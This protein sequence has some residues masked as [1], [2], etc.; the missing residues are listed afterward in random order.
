MK[1]NNLITPAFYVKKYKNFF[2]KLRRLDFLAKRTS[3]K[4]RL[5]KSLLLALCLLLITESSPFLFLPRVYAADSLTVTNPSTSNTAVNATYNFTYS[6]SPTFWRIYIDADLNAGT[7]FAA[8][9]GVGADYLV[10]N[11]TVYKHAGGDWSWTEI[12]SAI[13]STSNPVV[14]WTIARNLIAETQA[15]GEKSALLF[16]VEDSTGNMGTSSIYNHVFTDSCNT[17]PTPTGAITPTP[18]GAITPTPTKAPTVTPSPTIGATPTP[19]APNT[20]PKITLTN[21]P[22][23][24]A[25]TG[26]SYTLTWSDSDPD[27]NALV[28]LYLD[29]DNTGADGMLIANNLKEDDNGGSGQ[30]AFDVSAVTSGSYYIYAVVE[31]KSNTPVISYSP[32]KLTIT[33]NTPTGGLAGATEGNFDVNSLGAATY[34]VPISVSPGTGGIQPK[35]SLSY[36]SQAGNGILGMGFAITGLSSISRCAAT[37]A[38]DGYSGEVTFGAGDKFCLDGE[39]LIVVSG[40]YGGNGAKYRTE[41]EQFSDIISSGT[42]GVGPDAFTVRT[43]AGLNMH[44]SSMVANGRSEA[45]YWALDKITDTTG[46][47]MTISYTQDVANGEY[48]PTQINYTGNTG[49][50][51]YASVKFVYEARSDATISYVAGS[52]VSST[53]RLKNITSYHGTSIVRDYRLGYAQ[54]TITNR[55]HLSSLTECGSDGKCFAPTRFNWDGLNSG[56]GQLLSARD[57]FMAPGSG[58]WNAHEA[59]N[60]F[61]GDFDGD[62]RE[63]LLASAESVDTATGNG[64]WRIVT[65]TGG[66]TDSSFVSNKGKTGNGIWYGGKVSSNTVV[67]D[68]DGDGVDDLAGLISGNTWRVSLSSKA[69]FNKSGSGDWINGLSLISGVPKGQVRTGDFNGDKKDDL[70]KYAD[71][72]NPAGNWRISFSQGASKKAFGNPALWM[73]TGSNGFG[74][75]L[76][77][78]FNGDLYDDLIMDSGGG[79]WKVYLSN[80]S[81]FNTPVAW[82]GPKYTIGKTITGDFNGDK[83]TDLAG[84]SGDAQNT[85]QICISNKAGFSCVDKQSSIPMTV[86]TIAGDFN[87]DKKADLTYQSNQAGAKWAVGISGNINIGSFTSSSTGMWAGHYGGIKENISGDFNGDGKMDIAG[88]SGTGGQF[89]VEL[90]TGS[91]YGAPGSGIWNVEN[92]L[93]VANLSNVRAGDFNADGKTDLVT[94]NGNNWNLAISTGTTFKNYPVVGPLT[95][96][97]NNMKDALLGDFDGDGRTDVAVNTGKGTTW[98]VMLSTGT[99]LGNQLTWDGGVSAATQD[100]SLGDFNGDGKTDM[101]TA[102]ANTGQWSVAI[103]TGTNFS[104][105][106]YKWTGH[107]GGN[108]NNFVADFNGDGKSDIVGYAKNGKWDVRLSTGTNFGGIGSGYWLGHWG[109]NTNNVIGDFNGDGM[110]DIAGYGGN[111]LWDIELST[112]T[113][114]GGIGS[115]YWV[116]HSG[117]QNNNI[118]ADFSGDGKTDLAGYTGANGVWNVVVPSGSQP[119]LLRNVINGNGLTNTIVYG[120]LN[121]PSI[122]TQGSTATYPR[123]DFAGPFYVVKNYWVSNGLSGDIKDSEYK[124][125]YSGAQTQVRGRGF[126]GFRQ[127]TIN[128]VSRNQ[129]VTTIYDQDH[130]YSGM[131][132]KTI[133][134]LGS[135]ALLKVVTN[136]LNNISSFNNKVFFSYVASIQED[137]FEPNS[138]CALNTDGVSYSCTPGATTTTEYTY[139]SPDVNFGNVSRVVIKNGSFIQTTSNTY[140]NDTSRWLLGRLSKVQVVS[141]AQGVP[142]ITRISTFAY[143]P[144]SGLLTKEITDPGTSMEVSKEYVRDAFGNITQTTIGSSNLVPRTTTTTFD[145]NKRFAIKST[146]P[147][148]QGAIKVYDQLLGNVITDTSPNGLSVSYDYDGF[149]RKIRETRPDATISQSFYLNCLSDCPQNAVYKIIEWSTG[150]APVI[151]YYDAL[152]RKLR[153]ET[154]NFNGQKVLTDTIYD[155]HGR[156]IQVSEP[157]VASDTPLW[158]VYQYDSAGRQV[159]ETFPDGTSSSVLYAGLTTTMTNQLGQKQ[160]KRINPKGWILESRDNA[161]SSM[162]YAYDAVGNTIRIDDPL[163]NTTSMT[164]DLANNKTK[165]IDPD[166]GT[167][168]YVYN[169]FGELVEQKDAKNQKT[170]FDYDKIGRLV[171]RTTPEGATTW[172]FDSSAKG[173]GKI[174]SISQPWSN[175]NEAYEYDTLGRPSRVVETIDGQAYVNDTAYDF[176]GHPSKVTYP[177]G[178]SSRSQ[179]HVLGAL[180][181]VRNGSDN[182]LYWQMTSVSPR[183]QLLTETFGNGAVS[184]RA[185]DLKNGLLS[186]I[187]TMSSSQSANVQSLTYLFDGIGNLKSRSDSTKGLIESFGYDGLNRLTSVTLNGATSLTMSYNEIGNLK[188]KSDVGSY[189]YGGLNSGTHQVRSITGALPNTYTYDLNGN[190][191]TSNTGSVTY[192]S[193]DKAK[194]IKEG[195]ATS[196]LTYGADLNRIKQVEVKGALSTTTLYLGAHEHRTAINNGVTTTEDFH[197]IAGPSGPVATVS[198]AKVGSA[199]PSTTTNYIH[200]DHLGSIDTITNVNGGV[201]QKLSFDAWGRRRDPITWK[202]LPL[203][204]TS[205]L[206]NRGFTGHEQLDSMNLINMNGRVYDPVIG[207]F[208][209][210]DPFVQQPDNTQSY[211][212]YSYVLNSPLSY[213]DPTGH[214]FRGLRRWISNHKVLIAGVIGGFVGAYLGGF[215]AGYFSISGVGGMAITAAGGGFGASFSSTTIGGGSLRDGLRAGL[216]GGL[217]GAAMAVAMGTAVKILGDNIDSIVNATDTMTTYEIPGRGGIR[218]VNDPDTIADFVAKMGDKANIRATNGML[219]SFSEA[220]AG[221]EIQFSKEAFLQIYNPT[222]GFA[223]DLIE[224]AYDKFGFCGSVCQYTARVLKSIDQRGVMMSLTSHSQGTL[225]LTGALHH[226]NDSGTYLNNIHSLEFLGPA[227]GYWD[228]RSLA[229]AN[230]VPLDHF[231]HWSNFVDFVGNGIGANS[232]NP[233]RILGS[234]AAIPS[235]FMGQTFSQHAPQSYHP[236]FAAGF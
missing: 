41:H 174:A 196:T 43:K 16:Q 59:S 26:N 86:S 119:D 109:G 2:T 21:P 124:I 120:T 143:D 135:G 34:S 126:R 149:G 235:L 209:S 20:S 48:Y 224:S 142:D 161:N 60:Y 112:G 179:Y 90:S 204:A 148:N 168:V 123:Y 47:Y 25:S 152:D 49:L 125:S 223:V 39:R 158:H 136:T 163:G 105:G 207:R 193:F 45:L 114:F 74:T 206:V 139:N 156:L 1:I 94:A 7:G 15:C 201:A 213:T 61:H 216:I 151:T 175:Y 222:H 73:A 229:I 14:G 17:T 107:T 218:L 144:A 127:V 116:G 199:A 93:P 164:Y 177:S 183:G 133:T 131:A 3:P 75:V 88:F 220:V 96:P 185:Y 192:T 160:I 132:I 18:T 42:K 205:T 111:G 194:V 195:T 30:Y 91:N 130:L 154:K 6:G 95:T 231:A 147:L 99:G 219:S 101:M 83:V 198:V 167:T 4:S 118:A 56:L 72:T 230:N 50:T 79:N 170:T 103:S 203:G 211:N 40:S 227:A 208:L 19:L 169:A 140:T 53:K 157:Y 28:S 35:L 65:S 69:D 70:I 214:F 234:V 76:I 108:G 97:A 64:L 145:S 122:H 31:D 225:I 23:A 62:Q 89:D 85:W 173:I 176:W 22:S 172:T 210:A 82:N 150:I 121:D 77:G 189:S 9:A 138:N 184:N 159:R 54:G 162:N 181:D 36:S 32:G 102:I 12:G 197:Y 98:A 66:V 191:L 104:T 190:R 115:G 11:G 38:S 51:P 202:V 44:Y 128:D 236:S 233:L 87:G 24:G 182:R 141:S 166:T 113:N 232:A 13:F 221:G 186:G 63:D 188:Y 67:G 212:R 8:N 228:A 100:V 153:S 33:G 146:N 178:L 106:S 137:S 37:F 68:F 187:T 92:V 217:E 117:G 80:G 200:L 78:N 155:W 29:K 226:L 134:Q 110:A 55:S 171:R 46:N 52:K 58:I 129:K 71:P 180:A 165:L 215:V 5:K 81:G 27:D 84:Y 57:T 10:E